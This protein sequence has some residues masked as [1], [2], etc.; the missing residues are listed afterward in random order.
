MAH[1]S[2]WK[3]AKLET[4]VASQAN[5]LATGPFGS[6]ISSKFFVDSGVPVIRGSNLSEDVGER[7]VEEDLVFLPASKAA[8]FSRSKAVEG[9]LIFT[10]WGTI[11]QV[12]LI[13]HR[14]KYQ[15]YIVSN[16]QMK[17]SP[18][19]KRTDSLFLY[20]LFS[21]PQM[22]GMIKGQAIGSS[23]P[24]FN[25][26]QL[27]NLELT[28]PPLE[29]QARVATVLG[30]LDDK[31]ELNRKM[32]RTL[33]EIA[34]TLFRAWFVDFEGE[35][36]LVESEVGPIPH[37]WSVSTVAEFADLNTQSWKKDEA[38]DEIEYLDLASVKWGVVG[39]PQRIRFTEA[40]SRAR[41]RLRA[42]DT[43]I[44]TVRPSNGSFGL[45]QD[46][47]PRLTGSTGFA[48]LSP[49]KAT[50]CYFL[51]LWLTRPEFIET[52]AALAHGS[53]YPAVRASAIHDALILVPPSK[54]LAR[55]H[56]MVEPVFS[57]KLVNEQQSKTLA[58]LRDTLLPKLLSGELRAP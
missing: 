50:F 37:G 54:Q 45:V 21:S 3:T 47:S 20:Y 39:E 27:R 15:E 53:A 48:V 56:T 42:G 32:N 55:F 14:A 16:K 34:Q 1:P 6:A 49:K 22:M 8:E 4:L 25:L 30:T 35:T 13:D 12:G 44:G 17:F 24:G 23:V 57:R 33:E 10:C 18:D 36:D 19:S 5:A 11:G 43:V 28:L 9:D 40:P 7:L 46:A 51:Y 58:D 2:S 41:R 38:P 26:S 52:L 29:E 31:I